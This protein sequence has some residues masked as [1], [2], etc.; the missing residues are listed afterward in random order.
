LIDKN[1]VDFYISAVSSVDGR[2]N[3]IDVNA[4]K[5]TFGA[6]IR[7]S[8]A[9]QANTNL[10]G[11]NRF[12]PNNLMDVSY[13]F[14]NIVRLKSRDKY[15]KCFQQYKIGVI[16]LYAELTKD[17]SGAVSLIVT[18]KLL[19]PIQYRVGVFGLS[20]GTSL[21]SWHFADYGVDI[22]K[23]AIW[24]DS[25]DGIVNISEE[26]HVDSWATIEIP[27]RTGDINIY[28]AIDPKKNQYIVSLEPA[29]SQAQTLSF[30]EGSNSFESFLSYHSEMMCTLGN[31]L[32]TFKDGELYTHDSEIYNRF[33]GVDYPSYIVFVFNQNPAES[34][35]FLS[36]D[37]RANVIWSCPDIETSLMSFGTTPQ[38]S[39]L[40][41]ADFELV[42]G[43]WQASF[44]QDQNSIAGLIEGDDLKGV[45][46]KIKFQVDSASSFI[47]LN[48][49]LLRYIDS[50]L[51]T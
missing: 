34:K 24:R 30:S 42:E 12:Y 4:K 37:E 51:N 22:P 26:G 28:G 50:P 25:N 45:W 8:E 16:P 20:T 9:Y 5:Q 36:V 1:F 19:N 38:Q 44:L 40:V 23:A 43:K 7:F 10:N 31:T 11:L 35:S 14:G 3:E 17:G 41:E 48:E 27:L 2:P 46:I 47:T 29:D 32:I 15:M 49:I 21:A 39:N 13:G 18:D 6:T 33:Y